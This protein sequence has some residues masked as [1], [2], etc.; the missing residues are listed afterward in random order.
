MSDSSDDE[1]L[2]SFDSD[3]L[4]RMDFDELQARLAVNDARERK[5]SSGGGAAAV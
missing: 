1:S 2:A 4:A 5:L 3:A